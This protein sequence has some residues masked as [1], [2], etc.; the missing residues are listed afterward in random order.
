METLKLDVFAGPIRRSDG[1]VVIYCKLGEW[2]GY[3]ALVPTEP[4]IEDALALSQG[5]AL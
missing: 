5:G 2:Y 4:T 1:T 3:Y